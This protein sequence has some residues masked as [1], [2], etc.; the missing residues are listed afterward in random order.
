MFLFHYILNSKPYSTSCIRI[1]GLCHFAC[2]Y[3]DS[4]VVLLSKRKRTIFIF[5]TVS[6][7]GNA[8]IGYNFKI[9][10]QE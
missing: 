5:K 4:S 6:L 10:H 2:L 9:E 8:E 7:N 1:P 3:L